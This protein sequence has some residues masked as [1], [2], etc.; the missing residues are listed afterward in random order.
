MWLVAAPPLLDFD[1][2]RLAFRPYWV[3]LSL[4][5]VIML[6][7]MLRALAPLD[8]PWL[9]TFSIGLAVALVAV[10]FLVQTDVDSAVQINQIVVGA[11]IALVSLMVAIDGGKW[12]G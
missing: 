8:V 2:S 11:A 1:A 3:P 4:A 5:V 9:R 7:G 6:A 12:L 10:A